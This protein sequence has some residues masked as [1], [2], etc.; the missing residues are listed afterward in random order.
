MAGAAAGRV[1]RRA[2]GPIWPVTKGLQPGVARQWPLTGS[3]QPAGEGQSE[4]SCEAAWTVLATMSITPEPCD[5]A[6]EEMVGPIGAL[7]VGTVGPAAKP[8]RA[9]TASAIQNVT[10]RRCRSMPGL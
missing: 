9:K 5:G 4:L 3:M 2:T 8:C 10:D 1:S 6:E 7:R